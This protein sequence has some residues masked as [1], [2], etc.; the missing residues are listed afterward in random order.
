MVSCGLCFLLAVTLRNCL[1]ETQGFFK[2]EIWIEPWFEVTV[3]GI[4]N[5]NSVSHIL[6]CLPP[7]HLVSLRFMCIKMI[8]DPNTS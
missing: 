8:R 2:T 4:V 3:K 6:A 5:D 7:S 1:N